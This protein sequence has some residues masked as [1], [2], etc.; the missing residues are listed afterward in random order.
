MNRP[1]LST[2]LAALAVT[3]VSHPSS[4]QESAERQEPAGARSVLAAEIAGLEGDIAVLEDLAAWQNKMIRAASSDP[5]T[6]LRQR[7]PMAECR[8][9][10][11]APV[12]ASLAALFRDGAAAAGAASG[13]AEGEAPR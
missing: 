7:R 10:P 11:L 4:A 12:C 3:V 5:A 9:S 6:T 1:T 2:V 13:A 8:A